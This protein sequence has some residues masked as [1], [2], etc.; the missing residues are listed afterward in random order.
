MAQETSVTADLVAGFARHPDREALVF[1]PGGS[2][3]A[4]VR[5]S[6][7]GLDRRA[8]AAAAR[9]QRLGA[10]G[11]QVMVAMEP[12]VDLVAALLGCL[13][14]GA[15]A[16]PAPPPGRSRAA[17]ER[18]AV[19]AKDAAVHLVLT[20]AALAG[21]FSRLLA[22][23]G[24]P[25][26][27][28]V[29]ADAPGEPTDADAWR[30][31]RLGGDD[32]AL[33]QYTSGTTSAPR[34]V[35]I[36]HANLAAAMRSVHA[37][38]GTTSSSRIGGW[39][40]YYHDLGLIGQL[41]HPLW[42]GATAVLMPPE[43]Y[44]ARPAHWLE[45]VTRHGVTVAAAPDSAYARCVAEVSD[46]ELAGLDLSRW[47]LA[48]D[49]AESVH[50]GT[51]AAFNRR[52]AAAGLRSGT[53]APAYGLA[54]ATLLVSTAAGRPVA[55]VPVDAL[56]LAH[57]RLAPAGPGAEAQLLV[58]S[59]RAAPGV[60]LAVVEPGSR[61]ELPPGAVGE[62]L[63]RGPMVS[64]GYWNRKLETAADFGLRTASG[65]SGFLA[66]GDLGALYRGELHVIGRIK[67]VLKV[68]GRALHP[69]EV[70]RQLLGCG[71]QLSSAAVFAVGGTREQLVV[72]QEV[73]TA[74]R[75]HGDR[76]AQVA[77]V[78]RCLA[79]EFGATAEG[80]V[81]VRPGTVRRT[82]SGKIRRSVMR[83]Q[84]LQ[85]EIRPLYAE[86]STEL[87]RTLPIGALGAAPALQAGP[88]RY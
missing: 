5:V 65:R 21:E 85:G 46:E 40:P 66:T 71:A 11:R 44:L 80:V 72:V 27:L 70:E 35:R 60:E 7:G 81:L 63:V 36:S 3:A 76:P 26:V 30:M 13:Y 64:A 17:A 19:I 38:L 37:A 33:I 88:S 28:C 49:A 23:A 55:P 61:V 14:A 15:V 82:T 18:T 32:L 45:A 1:Q 62:I 73:R 9:L 47:E 41:L 78:R 75:A 74:G 24:R 50:A 77:R 58:G 42:L 51:L 16:V 56:E 25:D 69:Q 2:P 59:G 52:F 31:P 48:V 8:R 54:E 20:Q 6:F 53:L 87:E 34:G 67:D 68:D 29:A 57:G 43:L 12:G 10:E 4:A 83:E 86:F 79:E 22:L 39:L 84:F